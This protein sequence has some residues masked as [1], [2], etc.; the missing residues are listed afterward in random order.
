MML[1]EATEGGVGGGM[2]L[3]VPPPVHA[4]NAMHRVAIRLKRKRPRRCAILLS[5]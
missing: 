4:V 1:T 5:P 2:E 3:N